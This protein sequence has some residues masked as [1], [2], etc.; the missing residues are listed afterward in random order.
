MTK[1]NET[2]KPKDK[3]KEKIY[4]ASASGYQLAN[5][6]KEKRDNNGGL[7]QPESP[8][9]FSNHVLITSD[10]KKQAHVES[11]DAFGSLI[12]ECRD[13]QQANKLTHD[14]LVRKQVKEVRST[15]EEKVEY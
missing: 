11:S 14:L 3:P 7:V 13:M 12:I 8:L 9:R 2:E 4:W 1:V 10:P 5:F 15:V 6:I